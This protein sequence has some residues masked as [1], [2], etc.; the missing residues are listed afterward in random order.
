M[1]YGLDSRTGAL[2]FDFAVAAF[3]VESVVCLGVATLSVTLI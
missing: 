1:K 3:Q 2:G